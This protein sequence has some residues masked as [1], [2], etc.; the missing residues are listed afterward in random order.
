MPPQDKRQHS[1]R[2][3]RWAEHVRWE[4][5]GGFRGGVGHDADLME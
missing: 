5:V 3:K 1:V 2:R 4:V